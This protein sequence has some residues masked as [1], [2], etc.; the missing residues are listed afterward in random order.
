MTQQL[1]QQ[2]KTVLSPQKYPMND[3]G[4][5]LGQAVIAA[6]IKQLNRV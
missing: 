2:G 1:Q 3:G 6:R 5:A 4:L